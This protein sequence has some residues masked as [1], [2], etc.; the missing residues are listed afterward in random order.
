LAFDP[1]KDVFQ[2]HRVETRGKP[3]LTKQ[4][5]RKQMS[6]FAKLPPAIIGIE[7]CRSVCYWTRIQ[8]NYRGMG[9]E[10]AVVRIERT[11]WAL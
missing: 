2:I 7:V 10:I 3:V 5:K 4:L 11:V 9:W 1:E 8:A 6:A